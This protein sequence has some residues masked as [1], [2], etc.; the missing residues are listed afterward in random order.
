MEPNYEGYWTGKIYGTNQGGFTLD[1]KQKD[2]QLSGL[3]KM[4]EPAIGQYEYHVTGEVADPL[5]LDLAPGRIHGPI[6]LGRVKVIC[7][8]EANGTLTGRW[9]SEIGTEGTFTATRFEKA[10]LQQE[11]PKNNSVFVVHGQDEATKQTVARYL[12][13]IGVQP[14]ILQEQINRGMSLIEKFEDYASRAGF[15]V[16]LMTP[17]DIGGPVGREGERKQ[18]ARQNVVLELGYF[19]AKLSRE[20]VVVLIKD[21]VELPS[22]VMGIV[23]ERMDVNEGWKFKLARELKAAGFNIDL[24][25][26]V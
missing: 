16:I 19:F 4:S 12:E 10:K 11:L 24:N 7:S 21:E 9:T 8:L 22:D 17:D 26:A 2:S 23:Y 25:N 6:E 3:A 15:A 5:T 14:V 20:R 1:L 13:K 18:R